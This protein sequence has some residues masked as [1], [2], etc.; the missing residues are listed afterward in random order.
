[1][2]GCIPGSGPELLQTKPDKPKQ[3]ELDGLTFWTMVA[4]WILVEL[5]LPRKMQIFTNTKDTENYTIEKKAF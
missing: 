1:L 3:D 2:P 5:Y 4:I